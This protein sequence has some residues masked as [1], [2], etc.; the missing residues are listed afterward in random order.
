MWFRVGFGLVWGWFRVHIGVV[1]VW[2]VHAAGF[3]LGLV[4]GG[5]SRV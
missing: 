2:V 4:W 1:R 3:G 5:L